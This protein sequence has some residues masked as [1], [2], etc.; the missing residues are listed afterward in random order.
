MCFSSLFTH[1]ETKVLCNLSKIEQR[2]L[3][4]NP[5]LDCKAYTPPGASVLKDSVVEHL[6]CSVGDI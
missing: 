4:L 5:D 1:E 2:S 3:D 6:L